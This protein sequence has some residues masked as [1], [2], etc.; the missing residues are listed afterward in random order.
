[1]SRLLIYGVP[2]VVLAAVGLSYAW[3]SMTGPLYR[4]GDVRAGKVA[5]PLAPATDSGGRWLVAPNIELYHFESGTG[6]PILTVHGG[7]GFPPTQPW[8]AAPLLADRFRLIYYHQRG[9]G[10]STRPIS[11]FPGP[12]MYGNMRQ[13]NQSLGLGAQVADI[14]RIRGILGVDKLILIGHS[15]GADLAAFYA[16][17]FPEHIRALVYVAPAD[18]VVM[19]NPDSDLFS[20]VRQRLPAGMR[21]EYEAY[22]TEYLDFGRAFR[23]TEAESSAFYGRFANYYGAATGLHAPESSDASAA[24][25]VPLAAFC[26]MG[27][28]HDYSAALRAIHAPVLVIHGANDLQPESASRHFAAYFGGSR[29]VTVEGAGHFVFDDRPQEFAAAVRGFLTD[30]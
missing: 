8:R 23:R 30:L 1:M 18:L 25:F 12:N 19:P 20:L 7:P 21:P 17:E 22:M 4:P 27:K 14:E 2:L 3:Q 24:G 15:F 9:C 28:H 5:E 6:T 29:F 16:A 26:G 13:L 11:S 10:Q